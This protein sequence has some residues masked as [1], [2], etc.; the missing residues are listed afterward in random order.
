MRI[1][2]SAACGLFLLVGC[3]T[4]T[5]PA[6]PTKT[7]LDS[8]TDLMVDTFETSPDNKEDQILDR[9]VRITSPSLDGIWVYTQLNTGEERKLYRQR[10]AN[11]SAS[12]DGKNIIQK[13][14]GLLEPENFENAWETPEKLETLTRDNI[15]KYFETGCEMIWTP[16][17][18]STW[19]GYVDP[20]KCKVA[21]KRR[22]MDIHIESEA[23]LGP[24]QYQT[25]ER[26]FDSEMI[27]L[28]GT[29]PGVYITLKRK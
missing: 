17:P 9:R 25:N 2:V 12:K 22:N 7:N 3:A 14:Y 1:S 16:T 29:P 28:W 24:D 27:Q 23:R 21:S 15:E 4:S 8:F 13:T 6:S 19:Q 11:L 18:E 5:P 20:A 26:G 10:V